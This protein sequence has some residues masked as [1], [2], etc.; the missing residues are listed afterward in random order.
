MAQGFDNHFMELVWNCFWS[1]TGPVAQLLNI[2]GTS[3]I[4]PMILEMPYI[5]PRVDIQNR[6]LWTFSISWTTSTTIIDVW[7]VMHCV[8]EISA[9]APISA[10]SRWSLFQHIAQCVLGLIPATLWALITDGWLGSLPINDGLNGTILYEIGGIL[11]RL[12]FGR[13]NP[14]WCHLRI[15]WCCP[16]LMTLWV[17]RIEN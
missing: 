10:S 4:S 2:M 1:I 9:E 13:V 14:T 16:S 15:H 17:V 5:F 12:D 7:Q 6:R 8:L 11:H 3:G